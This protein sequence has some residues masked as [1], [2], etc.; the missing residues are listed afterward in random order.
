LGSTLLF[1]AIAAYVV[2]APRPL[3]PEPELRAQWSVAVGETAAQTVGTGPDTGSG[4]A[5]SAQEPDTGGASTAPIGFRLGSV[6]GYVD[7]EGQ[8]ISAESVYHDVTFNSEYYVNFSAVSQN[9]VV[10]DPEGNVA[11]SIP[12]K[13]Y[14]YMRGDRLFLLGPDGTA[15]SEWTLNGKRLWQTRLPAVFTDIDANARYLAAAGID[16]GVRL[17]DANGQVEYTYRD[18][19]SRLPVALGVTVSDNADQ[20]AAVVG[21]DPQR[22]VF[23]GRD[24]QGFFP[25]GEIRLESAFRRPVFVDFV[26]EDEFLAYES[27]QGLR[28]VHTDTGLERSFAFSG[29]LHGFGTSAEQGFAAMLSGVSGE[30]GSAATGNRA[31]TLQMM[32]RSG[33]VLARAGFAAEDTTLVVRDDLIVLGV[34]TRL[35]GLEVT[36]L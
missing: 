35:L 21:V 18:T 23:F 13:G 3:S 5:D 22:L 26:F 34:D 36:G 20:A 1:F 33:E 2:L 30:N 10:R 25:S 14:P 15:I 31:N 7:S 29:Q 17:V 27:A 24:E 19:T 12:A 4:N 9:A 6:F 8:L 16:G 11:A 28:L 32:L